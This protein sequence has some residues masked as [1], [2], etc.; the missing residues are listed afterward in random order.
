MSYFYLVDGVPIESTSEIAGATAIS[1]QDSLSAQSPPPN[2]S[3]FRIAIAQAVSYQ[4]W[5][6][7][8]PQYRAISLAIAASRDNWP[9]V[10]GIYN[11]A[12]VISPPASGAR[13]EWQAIATANHI[14][15]DF[16]S[17]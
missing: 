16:G 11:A 2:G 1:E 5:V 4:A 7:S 3:G 14:P 10:Q 17:D 9:E 15:L 8:L 6:N 12:V 13:A